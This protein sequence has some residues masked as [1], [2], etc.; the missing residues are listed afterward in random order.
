ME[1]HTARGTSQLVEGRCSGEVG[2]LESQRCG[3]TYLRKEHIS[4]H[5]MDGS[6]SVPGSLSFVTAE[7]H[8]QVGT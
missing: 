6:L 4:R 5:F 1:A 2:H 8:F 3:S 7:Q